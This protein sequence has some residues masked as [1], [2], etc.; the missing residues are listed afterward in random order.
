MVVFC[1]FLREISLGEKKLESSSNQSFG[2]KKLELEV[3]PI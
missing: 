2:E 1:I 3:P